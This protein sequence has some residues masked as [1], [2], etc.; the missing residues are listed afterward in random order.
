MSEN[1]SIILNALAGLQEGQANLQDGL[2]SLRE[3]QASLQERQA[4]FQEGLESLQEGQA[5][6]REGQETVAGG[7]ER[8]EA[9]VAALSTTIDVVRSE[10]LAE[11]G[12]TRAEVMARLQNVRNDVTVN[13][14]AAQWAERGARDAI[15]QGRTLTDMLYALTRQ[16]RQ[17]Q[18]TVDTLREGRASPG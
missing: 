4:S 1:L 16:V 6:L 3:G 14:A 13:L 2:A 15:D 17:L 11:L 8:L 10:F 7:Q 9:R 18:D 5:S 12:R